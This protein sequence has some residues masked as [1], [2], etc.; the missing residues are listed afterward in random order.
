MEHGTGQNRFLIELD[1]VTAIRASEVSGGKLKHTPFSLHESNR[2][3]PHKGR[4]N[5]EVEE[6]VVKHA[7]ALNETGQEFFSWLIAFARGDEVERRTM[8]VIVLDEDGRTPVTTYEYLNCVPVTKGPES[9]SASSSDAS[10]FEFT[11]APE[12]M[13]EL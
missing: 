3:N 12:D 11:V 6:V 8:R 13:E 2:A 1:G 9:H 10:M 7:H 5:Y 4:G